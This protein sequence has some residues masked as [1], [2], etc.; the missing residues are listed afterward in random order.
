MTYLAD[1]NVLLALAWQHHPEHARVRAWWAGLGKGDVFATCAITELGF[2]RISLQPAF[3]S[4]DIGQ[5]RQTLAQMRAASPDHV[6]LADSLG[7]A[8]LPAWVKTAKHT[9]DGHL[10]ALAD[11]SGAKLVTLDTGIPGAIVV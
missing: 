3:G 11:A 1:V 9:T 7:A 4:A 10:L 6:L 2:V 8:A 5:A